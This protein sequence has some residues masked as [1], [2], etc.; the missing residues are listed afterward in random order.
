MKNM[1]FGNLRNMI[2]YKL[3]FRYKPDITSL[4]YALLPNSD[5][6]FMIPKNIAKLVDS[7]QNL[8]QSDKLPHFEF[9]NLQSFI[10]QTVILHIHTRKKTKQQS[11]SSNKN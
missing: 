9:N 2:K 8:E 1:F 7:F 6:S 4:F 11:K 3:I 5:F 10:R